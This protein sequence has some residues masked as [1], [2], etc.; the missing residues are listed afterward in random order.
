MIKWIERLFGRC[1]MCRRWFVYP[2]KR[3]MS[4]MYLDMNGNLDEES[5][6]CVACKNCY[7]EIEE[8]ADYWSSR[9]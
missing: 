3:R 2:K 5:N 1:G 9:L 8:W 4:T 7:E 6:H